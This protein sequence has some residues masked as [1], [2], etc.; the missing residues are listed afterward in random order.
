[1]KTLIQLKSYSVEFDP[2]GSD[3]LDDDFIS[4]NEAIKYALGILKGKFKCKNTQEQNLHPQKKAMPKLNFVTNNFQSVITP[5]KAETISKLVSAS[6]KQGRTGLN[7][8]L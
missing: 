4:K 7:K 5:I 6:F 8:H 2:I 1:V 3:E